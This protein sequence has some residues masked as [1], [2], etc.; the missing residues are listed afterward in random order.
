MGSKRDPREKIERAM[1]RVN[2]DLLRT[3]E[4]IAKATKTHAELL[5][6]RDELVASLKE[7]GSKEIRVTDHA[8]IRFLERVKGTL[9]IEAIEAE[10]VTDELQLIVDQLGGSGRL[11]LKES[12]YTVVLKDYHIIT[13]MTEDDEGNAKNVPD[14][15]KN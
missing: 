11:P 8:I 1:Q 10:I 13:V 15:D 7:L 12:G 9:D 5:A 2:T 6:K 4:T 14:R 3:A